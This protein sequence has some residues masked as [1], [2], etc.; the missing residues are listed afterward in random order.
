MGAITVFEG[1]SA[2]CMLRYMFI[3]YIPVL[4][5]SFHVYCTDRVSLRHG[6]LIRD[7]EETLVSPGRKF[8]L[9]FFGPIGGSEE[10]R[11][12]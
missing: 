9:G 2:N 4:L 11:Y 7:N 12:V 5:F 8:E 3:L 1:W 6:E 10:E